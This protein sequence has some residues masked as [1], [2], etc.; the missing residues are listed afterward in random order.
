MTVSLITA[1]AGTGK[2]TRLTACYADA[3][4]G[5]V[6]PAAVLATTFTR[7][8]AGELIERVRARLIREDPA[9]AHGVLASY[10]GTID[11]V[12]GR[13]VAEN[14]LR[15]G[16]SPE[17]K[18]I[19]ETEQSAFFKGA[20]A[21]VMRQHAPLLGPCARRLCIEDWGEQVR[22][23]IEA[24]RPNG[25]DAA[26]LRTCGE[27]SWQG[28]AHL[29]DEPCTGRDLD[30]E[31]AAALAGAL[32]VLERAGTLTKQS[33][34]V[35]AEIREMHAILA[36]G[37]DLTWQQWAKLSKL[38]PANDGKAAVLP[39]Q[40]V[41]AR[42]PSHP[43]LHADL[44]AFVRGA[45][46]CAAEAL[47][48]YTSA[49]AHEGTV[50][51]TD[52][53]LMALALL[54]DPEVRCELSQRLRLA[55]VDE[56]QDTNPLQLALFTALAEVVS[57]SVWVGDQ[58]QAIYGFR[59]T[60]PELVQE[61]AEMIQTSGGGRRE[62]LET[63][64][65]SRPEIV[66]FVN[67]LFTA[68]FPFAGI[69][70][71][72]VP[73]T[74]HRPAGEAGLGPA[75]R[76]WRLAASNKGH[77]AAALAEGVRCIVADGWAVAVKGGGQRPARGGDVAIL[78]NS[79]DRCK[80]I[81]QA[82]ASA[83]LKVAIPRKGL[84]TTPEAKVAVAA[85]R[86]L[87]DPRDTLALAE[88]VHLHPDGIAEGGWLEP[89][90]RD[91]AAAVAATVGP[92]LALEAARANLLHLTPA[93]VLDVAISAAG[94][95]EA[96]VRWGD[97]RQRLANLDALRGLALRYQEH[98]L[99]HR[100]AATAAGFVTWLA[101]ESDAEQPASPDPDAVVVLTYHRAKGLEW[102]ITILYDL[103]AETKDSPFGL[104][105]EAPDGI[106]PRRPL[107]GRW[108]RYWPWPYGK[109]Q[110]DVGIDARAAATPEAAAAQRREQG[111]RTRVLY[112]G[113][114]R[115][116]DTLILTVHK[117][118]D[119]LD[120]LGEPAQRPLLVLPDVDGAQQAS[121]A[122]RQHELFAETLSPPA[123]DVQPP[124]SAAV[125]IYLPPAVPAVSH[126]PLRI[127][128]SAAGVGEAGRLVEIIRIN[129][130]LPFSGDADMATVGEAVHRF[131]AADRPHFPRERRIALAES[132][133]AR[134]RVTALAPT[135]LVS[136]ADAF[137]AFVAARWPDAKWRRE[138]PVQGRRGNQRL[139][140]R[141]DLL[142]ETDSGV[143][144]VDHKSFPGRPD[145]WEEKVES[146][147]PQLDLYEEMVSA[148]GISVITRII[149]MSVAGIISE[150]G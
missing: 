101:A 93:Q 49:K 94:I 56:F 116:R 106:D 76:L 28:L 19:D 113:A 23:I 143:V 109:Q 50:D 130:R 59:G 60:D 41:A 30:A 48:L 1:S 73:V 54:D 99:V 5:G 126:P 82:L 135:D 64:Y 65:R 129:G 61:V 122:R 63:C 17:L 25:I 24:A 27:R 127:A 96:A 39:V 124:A 91:G 102:P 78:C 89:W 34:G 137:A 92:A 70:A 58:K 149:H 74:A 43:R 86:Y 22:K 81:A 62:S 110:K 112:V 38:K 147:R 40:A 57:D 69:P 2:T 138:V 46:D 104:H 77:A 117:K 55:L 134:W 84:M 107:A 11:S 66:G 37:Q 123:D 121:V 68:A 79:N 12:C 42:H 144:L 26:G 85:L 111:E 52:Q 103:D 15:L 44:E 87:V 51:F 21:A 108:L 145:Q 7:K 119:W 16:L 141:I 83:G 6:T 120:R 136:S 32:G 140:G 33:T 118:T 36:A 105:V 100:G 13:L 125:P 142:L 10:I 114:T 14:A 139:V 133:L 150:L 88:L 45:F 53:E 4:A 67:D 75:L 18:V 90:L 132:I 29:I 20:V 95:A 131:F 98:A 35:L 128:P 31:L 47:E 3:V 148:N 72:D 97:P 80:E 8:A 146:H 71:A 9:A 115:A